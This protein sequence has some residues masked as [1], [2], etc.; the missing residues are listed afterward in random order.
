MYT[1]L[2]VFLSVS[3]LCILF[4]LILFTELSYRKRFENVSLSLLNRGRIEGMSSPLMNHGTVEE[5]EGKDESAS[6]ASEME[7]V[8]SAIVGL[9][10]S[11]GERKAAMWRQERLSCQSV[12]AVTTLLLF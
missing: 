8:V 10:K 4:T 5:K 2:L 1:A 12:A 3:F 7:A 6:V 11:K 9:T